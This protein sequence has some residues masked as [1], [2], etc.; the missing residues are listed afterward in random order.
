MRFNGMCCDIRINSSS[1]DIISS[2]DAG[3]TYNL[4]TEVE[5]LV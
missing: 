3:E 2:H 5:D 4:R 1:G